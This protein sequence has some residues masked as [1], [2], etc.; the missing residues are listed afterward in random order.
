MATVTMTKN[1]SIIIN[2]NT[3]KFWTCSTKV[4]SVAKTKLN[5]NCQ[6]HSDSCFT[7]SDP[8]LKFQL[9]IE[10][11]IESRPELCT[12]IVVQPVAVSF[13]FFYTDQD[14]LWRQPTATNSRYERVSFARVMP[15]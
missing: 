12:N 11:P 8:I 10:I 9:K 13:F 2:K 3:L 15:V 4:F 5:I 7:S 6:F 1:S 14:K